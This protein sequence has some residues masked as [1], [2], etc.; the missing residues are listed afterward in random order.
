M[1]NS[2]ST[3]TIVGERRN[4]GDGPTSRETE[5]RLAAAL[6]IA[7]LGTFEWNILTGSVTCDERSREIFGF[8][9]AEG[10]AINEVIARIHPDDVPRVQA[11]SHSSQEGL[12][13]L[14]TEY[15]VLLPDGKTRYV[16][17]ITHPIASHD[18]KAERIFGVQANRV[19]QGH[20]LP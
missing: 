8:A 17:S 2:E 14:E 15:R 16:A 7:K 13:R 4:A 9:G 18:G 5:A 10:W 12:T 20:H 3:T 19:G 1:A 11:E 6:A